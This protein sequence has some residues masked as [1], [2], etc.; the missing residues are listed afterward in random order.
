MKFNPH[1]A[2]ITHGLLV[3]ISE[4]PFTQDYFHE[5]CEQAVRG[6][7]DLRSSLG[8]A[9]RGAFLWFLVGCGVGAVALMLILAINAGL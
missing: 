4:G 7:M 3:K 1:D 2:P 9:R 8:R 5:A 6:E